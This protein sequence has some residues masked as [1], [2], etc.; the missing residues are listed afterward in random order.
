LI[1]R[2]DAKSHRSD[3]KFQILSLYLEEGVTA[4]NALAEDLISTF[5]ACAVWHKSPA[6]MI[7]KCSSPEFLTMLQR[8]I[9]TC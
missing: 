1:A 5:S 6:L 2:M 8:K 3:K 7:E 9:V 4:N